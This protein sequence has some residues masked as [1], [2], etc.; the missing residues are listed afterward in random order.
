LAYLRELQQ[1]VDLFVL[2]DVEVEDDAL[3]VQ[4]QEV[5][6]GG[7][8]DRLLDVLLLVADVAEEVL[9]LLLLDELA[10]ALEEVVLVLDLQRKVVEVLEALGLLAALR[11]GDGGAG[12]AAEDVVQQLA[13]GRLLDLVLELVEEHVQ[14]LA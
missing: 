1:R 3:E 5:G 7:H 11:A 14:E 2:H 12:L 13:V 4:D 10:E 8:G 9:H 6:R